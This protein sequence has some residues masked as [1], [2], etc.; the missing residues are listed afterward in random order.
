MASQLWCDLT[1]FKSSPNVQE[2]FF[3]H[4]DFLHMYTLQKGH[5][6]TEPTVY[7]YSS[8]CLMSDGLEVNIDIYMYM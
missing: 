2:Y 6:C 5:I 3:P 7:M 8:S 4:I 1:G